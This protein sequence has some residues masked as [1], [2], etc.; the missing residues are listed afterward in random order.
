MQGTKLEMF[1]NRLLKV[2]K[3]RSK[4]ARRQG[5]SCYRVYD[6]DLPEFPFI[7][8]LYEDKLYVSEY[9]RRHGLSDEEHEQW[10]DDCMAV[11]TKVLQVQPENIFL[12]MRQRKTGRT[13]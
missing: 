7:L 6:H 8:E 12:K 5:I 10:L 3:H 2:Y 9:K 4:Q 11:M 1:E 13:G